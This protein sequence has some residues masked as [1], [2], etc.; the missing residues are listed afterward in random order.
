M[1]LMRYVQVELLKCSVEARLRDV[2]QDIGAELAGS[3]ELIENLQAKL[4][5]EQ[6]KVRLHNTLFISVTWDVHM[7]RRAKYR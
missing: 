6:T 3:K 1:I 2:V 4:G 7:N 5:N